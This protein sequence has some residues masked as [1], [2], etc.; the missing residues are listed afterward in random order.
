MF[1][2][3]ALVAE[4]G[5]AGDGVHVFGVQEADELGQVVDVNLMLAQQRM[6]EGNI[7]AA[8]GVFDIEDHGVAAD[9]APVADNPEAVVAGR[10]DAG[11]IDGADLKIFWH[12]DCLLGDGRGKNSRDSNPLAGFQYVAGVTSIDFADS[13]GELRRSEVAGPVQVLAS[14]RRDA[15]TAFRSV[16][17]RSGRS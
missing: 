17:L 8:V 7:H 4:N 1:D 15:F 9:F 16:Y 11:E 5:N 13:V 6:L 10:H 14:D 2:Y 3:K 12:R